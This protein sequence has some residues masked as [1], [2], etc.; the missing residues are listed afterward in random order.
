[1]A[2]WKSCILNI[3]LTTLHGKQIGICVILERKK[4]RIM[5]QNAFFPCLQ[6]IRMHR[7]KREEQKTDVW[8]AINKI[9][10][11]EKKWT[12]LLKILLKKILI[13][14]NKL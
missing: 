7:S 1:M 3:N 13:L 4:I 6:G 5:C 2:G 10:Q 14:K 11:S 9:Q 8:S 12:A